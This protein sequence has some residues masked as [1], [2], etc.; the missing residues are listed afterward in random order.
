MFGVYHILF[1]DSR[2]YV[3]S[4]Q[5]DIKARWRSHKAELRE[6]QHD[7]SNL[8]AAWNENNGVCEFKVLE[9]LKD[10]PLV[11]KREQFYLDKYRADPAYTVLNLFEPVVEGSKM[12]QEQK[13]K[14]SRTMKNQVPWNRGKKMAKKTWSEDYS[15]DIYEEQVHE[16][17]GVTV[18]DAPKKSRRPNMEEHW[19]RPKTMRPDYSQPGYSQDLPP[20]PAL[21]PLEEDALDVTARDAS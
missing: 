7:N 2:V 3:G 10:K 12:P 19:S 21:P 16:E 15:A 8:Q 14:I 11:V 9:I 1:P 20:L 5:Y 4:T 6:N 17:E 18:P 13:D